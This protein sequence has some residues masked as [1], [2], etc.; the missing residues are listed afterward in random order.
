MTGIFT[1]NIK[2]KFIE[3]FIT[4]VGS[5]N[6]NYYVSFG[7]FFEW[8][9]DSNPPAA[10]ASIKESQINVNKELLIGKKL[11]QE[12]MSY[13]ASKKIWT[14]GTVY[15]YYSHLDAELY[16]K[17]YYVIN[18]V[19]RVY[20]CLFNN[21]GA[22]STVEPNLTINNGDFNTSDG[23]K[24]KYMFTVNSAKTKLFT[25][26]EY[27]P[28]VPEDTVV[29]FAEP[30]AIH[31][32]KVDASGNN[33]ISAN[34]YIDSII[35]NTTFKISNTNASTISGAFINSTFYIYSGSGTGGI[36]T[37][38]NYVVNNSGKYVFTNNAIRNID[39]TSLYRIDPQ[40]YFSGDGYDAAA[41]ATVN[42]LSGQ[43]TNIDM[44][45]RGYNYTYADI[46]IVSNT[47]FGS[48]ASAQSIISPPGGHGSDSVTEL[49]CKTLGVSITT[50]LTDN[51][52]S[53]LNY[54]QIALMYNPK[55]TANNALFRN[56]T[57]NQ[58]L[59]F[60]II[61]APNLFD[62]G[63]VI[64]G[65]NSRA[66]ATVAFMNTSSLYVLGDT[67][68]FQPF[69]T[70]VS[71]SSGKVVIVSTINNKDLV[72]YTSEILYYKNIEPISREGVA[73]EDVKLYFN[74]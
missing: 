26:D 63:E 22:E 10:N 74:F 32:I 6:S 1:Q 57:F 9:D 49:G 19:N 25:T 72:P 36:S 39:S 67:G 47:N 69:E 28:I 71:L 4:D 64:Q 30:G 8:S 27:F 35:S 13:V 65:I 56:S 43:I 51:F 2:N 60:G 59:N 70:L 29:Q 7:K 42:A 41:I 31:V 44:V 11:A 3:E 37:I 17:E 16:N 52:P 58:I 33:Y 45:N 18:S 34:G 54:R 15:D 66:S 5:S 38:T 50:S 68:T 61:S 46:S 53:W 40:V 23:Y 20:K 21:Y 14:S 12:N 24:W 48:G 73:S 55:A 62:E